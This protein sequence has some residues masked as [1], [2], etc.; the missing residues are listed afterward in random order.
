MEITVN[1]IRLYYEKIGAGRP[2]IMVHCNSMDHKIFRKAAQVLSQHYTVY[3][4][5]SRDHGKSEYCSD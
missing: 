4:P 3:L 1:G 5:D 2:L